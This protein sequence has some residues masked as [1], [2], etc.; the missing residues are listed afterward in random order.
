M[1]VIS[2]QALNVV[3]EAWIPNLPREF[4]IIKEAA[5]RH[6]FEVPD[7]KSHQSMTAPITELQQRT[8]CLYGRFGELFNKGCG[9][10]T[11]I[12][13]ERAGQYTDTY[14][15]PSHNAYAAVTGTAGHPR[16][17]IKEQMRILATQIDIK[18]DRLAGGL[19]PDT[20][21][22]LA[23]FAVAL[24]GVVREVEVLNEEMAKRAR[25]QPSLPHMEDCL[26]NPGK[27]SQQRESE[28]IGKIPIYHQLNKLP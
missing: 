7:N 1:K 27:I 23:A 10:I 8:A 26:A 6:A 20:V 11:N 3:L 5:E 21:Y 4:L 28:D 16:D 2:L 25:Q 19:K 9:H 17:V 13:T 14:A 24:A 12:I 15:Y 18:Y 22:D